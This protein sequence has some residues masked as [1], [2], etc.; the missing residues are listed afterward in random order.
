[1]M[2][3]LIQDRA[4][5]KTVK[6]MAIARITFSIRIMDVSVQARLRTRTALQKI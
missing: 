3:I 5:I 2:I 4:M 1:M 6:M